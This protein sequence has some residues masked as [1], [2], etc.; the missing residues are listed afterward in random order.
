M[1]VC[2][3]HLHIEIRTHGQCPECAIDALRL[4]VQDL[5]LRLIALEMEKN[6]ERRRKA[7]DNSYERV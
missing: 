4:D 5:T 6:N 2:S 7:L 3:K 1:K